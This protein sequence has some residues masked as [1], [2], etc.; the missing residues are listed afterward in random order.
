MRLQQG[1]FVGSLTALVIVSLAAVAC[2]ADRAPKA[3]SVIAK[4]TE[5][6]S[7]GALSKKGSPFLRTFSG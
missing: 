1:V 4:G 5:N 3:I 7:C 2:A 6:T